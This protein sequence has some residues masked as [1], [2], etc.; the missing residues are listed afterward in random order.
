MNVLVALPVLIPLIGAGLALTLAGNPRLQRLVTVIA[1]VS[2]LAIAVML[3]VLANDG[4]VSFDIGGWAAP[5]GI[6]IVAYPLS[7]LLMVI[8][9]A[10][11]IG[12][13]LSLLATGV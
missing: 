13:L 9:V 2:V 10:V 7:A 12:V 3:L 5:F 8:S 11:T 1:L 6:A 4:T